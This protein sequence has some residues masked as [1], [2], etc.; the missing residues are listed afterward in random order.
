MKKTI[1]KWVG[2]LVVLCFA[3]GLSL[4]AQAQNVK[5]NYGVLKGGIYS[6]QNSNFVLEFATFNVGFLF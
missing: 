3:L 2:G 1:T 4:P 5:A 6:P